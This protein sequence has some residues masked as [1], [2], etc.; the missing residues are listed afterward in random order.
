MSFRSE[1]LHKKITLFLLWLSL[2]TAVSYFL[3]LFGVPLIERWLL[4]NIF[5]VLTV[6]LLHGPIVGSLVAA[7]G[8]MTSF[9][10]VGSPEI[11]FLGPVTLEALTVSLLT[12]FLYRRNKNLYLVILL[13]FFASKIVLLISIWLFKAP[14][15]ISV[16]FLSGLVGLGLQL[17]FVPMIYT[18]LVKSS[19]VENS[20]G[21]I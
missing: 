13:D 19:K 14:I 5:I 17:I 20:K 18:V 2:S 11:G 9:M 12:S 8:A 7:F 3:Q 6:T 21:G 1:S 16:D 10:A 15:R 4:P